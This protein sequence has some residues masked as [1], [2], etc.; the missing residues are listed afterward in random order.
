MLKLLSLHQLLLVLILQLQ[1]IIVKALLQQLVA[2][3]LWLIPVRGILPALQC[4][5]Y[6]TGCRPKC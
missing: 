3:A 6:Q 5:V 2:P 1:A 4:Q